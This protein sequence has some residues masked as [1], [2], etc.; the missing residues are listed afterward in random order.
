MTFCLKPISLHKTLTFEKILGKLLLRHRWV[1]IGF[2]GLSQ[3]HFLYA[4]EAKSANLIVE[5]ELV[6]PSLPQRVRVHKPGQAE[7]KEPTSDEVVLNFSGTELKNV[8]QVIHQQTGERFLFDEA[9]LRGK[10]VTFYSGRPVRKS[11]LMSTLTSILEIQNLALVRVGVGEDVIF[12]IVS[13]DKA[14]KN[15][16][17]TYS[18]DTVHLI[19][20]SDEIVTLL[21][22][23]QN[24][25]PNNLVAP[26]N[27]MASIPDA[28]TAI[29]GSSLIKITDSAANVKRMVELI[30]VMD[31]S[32]FQ[33]VSETLK[34]EHVMA[35]RLVEELQPMIDV[36]NDKLARDIQTKMFNAQQKNSQV[37]NVLANIK[38]VRQIIVNAIDRLNSIFISGTTQQLKTMKLVIHSL[39]VPEEHR[40][41]I[42]FYV[43]KN[44][45]PSE[46]LPLLQTI[47]GG[48][49][50]SSAFRGSRS[51]PLDAAVTTRKAGNSDVVFQADDTRSQLM[52][53]AAEA[54]QVHIQDMVQRLDEPEQNGITQVYP[55]VNVDIN[56][57]ESQLKTLYSFSDKKKNALPFQIVNDTLHTSLIIRASEQVHQNIKDMLVQLDRAGEDKRVFKTYPLQFSDATETLSIV[58]NT[59]GYHSLKSGQGSN[60]IL[61]ADRNSNALVL[62]GLPQS[63]EQLKGLLASLDQATADKQVTQYYPLK[64]AKPEDVIKN[65]RELYPP[66]RTNKTTETDFSVTID[67]PS[68]TLILKADRSKQEQFKETILKLDIDGEDVR[69]VKIYDLQYA[70]PLETSR[71]LTEILG[72]GKGKLARNASPSSQNDIISV[73]ATSSK[74]MVFGQ[75]DTHNKVI[76][77]LMSIDVP[78]AERFQTVFYN[79]TKA[80]PEALLANLVQFFS[81]HQKKDGVKDIYFTLNPS[82]RVILVKALPEKQKEVAE[83]IRK[84]DISGTDPRQL[85]IYPLTYASAQ[86]VAKKLQSILALQSSGSSN[87]RSTDL[88]PNIITSDDGNSSVVL[89]AVEEIHAVVKEALVKLDTTTA[90][91]EQTVYYKVKNIP[92]MDAVYLLTEVFGLQSTA[93]PSSKKNKT[94][95]EQL[96]LDENSNTLIVIGSPK[97]NAKVKVFLEQVDVPG[98]GGNELKYYPI[99]NTTS[100][101]AAKTIEQLFGLPTKSTSVLG[102]VGGSIPLQRNPMVI[103]N[104]ESNTIIVNA[105]RRT[106]EAVAAM[107]SS[108]GDISKLDKMTVRFYPLENT[109]ANDIAGKIAELFSLKLGKSQALEVA[110]GKNIAGNKQNT[111]STALLRPLRPGSNEDDGGNQ[112]AE[113]AA[114]PA[115]TAE[116][117]SARSERNAFFFDGQ[118]TIIPEVNLNAVILVAPNYLHEEVKKTLDTMDKRR[119]QVMVEVAIVEV[120]DGAEL[121][122]GIEL[123]YNG[124]DGG[125]GTQFGITTPKAGPNLPAS[126]GVNPNLAGGI[127]GVLRS[128]GSMPLVLR[129]LQTDKRLKVKSTPVLL[130]NDNEKA[131][132]SSLQKEPTT[133]TTQS[134]S[135]TLIAFRAFEQAGTDLTIT[136][137]ISQGEHIRLEI[138]LKVESFTGAPIQIGIPPPKSSNSLLTSVTVP[139]LQMVVIGGMV[140]EKISLKTEKVPLL[141]DI[142]LLGYLFKRQVNGSV[143]SKLYLFIKPHIL[144]KDKFEDL[145]IISDD[146]INELNKLEK[147]NPPKGLDDEKAAK[148]TKPENNANPLQVVPSTNSSKEDATRR[149][150]RAQ[151]SDDATPPSP[152]HLDL[153]VQ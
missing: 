59:L 100:Q 149:R 99:E 73:D 112:V 62:L 134:T 132:F 91:E 36:E 6:K 9:L 90:A 124:S 53:I 13:S 41:R 111:G 117:P 3:L 142:P 85:V 121:D 128:N 89:F 106:Q 74:L 33:T 51:Q 42:A 123:S 78:N 65:L 63:H 43:T 70:D 109:N 8:L 153:D 39:D 40:G 66:T 104:V 94:T 4:D 93:V 92:I 113:V 7:K 23:L 44:R 71:L 10:S 61:N 119:P 20:N 146:K 145:R 138:D 22:K 21:Y 107:L 101:D 25:I 60:D 97:T 58:K 114:V 35:S 151:D 87:R 108:L 116:A 144:R 26:F 137:H 141:G 103:P 37:N 83:A 55:I 18:N 125:G 139:D 148:P 80:V 77:A 118:P 15:T 64:F 105:P 69:M 76:E 67:T 32:E 28:V 135:S 52:V 48:S 68:R 84:F 24:L 120:T 86:D 57:I 95:Q 115:P 143:Q 38:P 110:S 45:T 75:N 27:K 72:L 88:Y 127:A 5:E 50:T 131:T 1:K 31:E 130:V 96:I 54:L 81:I 34:V 133:T 150:S 14:S 19:P 56:T 79:I 152:Q 49:K 12:K 82:A 129:A 140:S 16:T 11:A 102:H 30:R 46:I 29:E 98:Q 126:G 147:M 17:P 2:L 122:F 47:Y 136:P